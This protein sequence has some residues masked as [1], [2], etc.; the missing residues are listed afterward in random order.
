MAKV[1]HLGRAT[2][3]RK[4]LRQ[5]KG[6]PQQ[7]EKQKHWLPAVLIKAEVISA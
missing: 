5:A 6:S 2:N 7:Q 4:L 3:L 1:L